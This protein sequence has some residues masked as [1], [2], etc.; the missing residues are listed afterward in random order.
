VAELRAWAGHALVEAGA[1]RDDAERLAPW[2]SVLA[3]PPALYREAAPGSPRAEALALLRRELG[4]APR[5]RRL[6]ALADRGRRLIA[7][8]DE[9]LGAAAGA[10]SPVDE[11]RRWHRALERAL[12]QA[13]AHARELIDDLEALGARLL[14]RFQEM[15]FGF[16]YDRSRHLFHIGHDLTA[17]RLD[18]NHYDLLASEARIAS[19]LAIAKGDAPLEHWLHL[20]RPVIRLGGSRVLLS[21][22][23]TMFEYLMPPLVSRVLA[24]TLLEES[25][26]V[27]VRHQ[28]EFAG[29]HGIPWGISESGFAELG[30][31]GDYQYRAF[32]VP[33]LGLKRGLGDRLVVAP[34]ACLLALRFRPRAVMRNVERL[35]AA[36]ALGGGGRG[37]STRSWPTTRG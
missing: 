32:G 35:I 23:A 2:H 21:W 17:G 8:L 14:R 36:G 4:A 20:G 27:A 24:R 10:G 22:G 6:P 15:D 13:A 7:A 16:L 5:L 19:L 37:S 11:A 33:G 18:P 29:R 1:A 31:H 25:C 3:R 12:D 34:Y 9:A 30:V 26:W 28:M